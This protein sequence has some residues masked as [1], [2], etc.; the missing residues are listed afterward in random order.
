MRNRRQTFKLLAT[1]KE[2]PHDRPEPPATPAMPPHDRIVRED[3]ETRLHR[4][5]CAKYVARALR[6]RDI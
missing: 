1:E 5:R 2:V 3:H 4:L 6:L